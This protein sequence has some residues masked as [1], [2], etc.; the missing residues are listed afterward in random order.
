M[1]KEIRLGE[2]F[3]LKIGEIAV[4]GPLKISLQSISGPTIK[5]G[6]KIRLVSEPSIELL[7]EKEKRSDVIVFNEENKKRDFMDFVFT[8][9]KADVDKIM[10]KV[11]WQPK[12]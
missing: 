12:K 5:T 10:I 4:L 6:G 8:L 2:P 1:E 7:V 11:M 3:V 9:L